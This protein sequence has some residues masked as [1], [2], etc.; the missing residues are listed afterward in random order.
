[1][2]KKGAII[3]CELGVKLAENDIIAMYDSEGVSAF[4]I[5]LPAIASGESYGAE[6]DGGIAFSYMTATKGESNEVAQIIAK[7]ELAFSVPGG[8]YDAKF[9][10]ELSV[11][12]GYTIY[13]TLDG[14]T[15]TAES[16]V[17][18]EPISITNRSGSNF[19]Y[20]KSEVTG[21]YAPSSLN[22]G[23]VVR[24]IAVDSKGAVAW[25]KTESYFVGLAN[26]SDYRNM[27]VISITTDPKNLFDYFEGIYVKGRTY[28]DAVAR[29][30][31]ATMA[32]NYHMGWEKEAYIE[33]YESNKD[34][35]YEGSVSLK[36]TNDYT[37]ANNQKSFLIKGEGAHIGSGLET[38]LNDI[39]K[40]L[41]LR[42]NNRDHGYKLRDYVAEELFDG[43]AA[44]TADLQPCI[45][46]I[47]GEYWGG[48]MLKEAYDEAYI[49][50]TY[51]TG[52]DKVVIVKNGFVNDYVYNS[53]YPEFRDFVINN[54]MS[55]TANYEMVK[56]QMDIQSY[57]DYICANMYVANAAYG[58]ESVIWRTAEVGGEGYCDGKWR[59]LFSEMTMTMAN[60]M[61]GNVST[62]S[63]DTFLQPGITQDAFLQSLLMN[64][65]FCSQLK[66][67][68]EKMAGETFAK[69]AVNTVLN[70]ISGSMQK[71]VLSSYKRFIGNVRDDYYSLEV[72][73]VRTFF[74]E[75]SEY[76]LFYTEELVEKGGDME[77]V[78]AMREML[79]AGEENGEE[80]EITGSSGEEISN[81]ELSE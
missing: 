73:K 74:E 28:E 3:V 40:S 42:T 20:A 71:F 49:K 63:I 46:F 72:E 62:A 14:T 12:E 45:V 56:K 75:R 32:A 29:G 79:K 2:M 8:F 80:G 54:D 36:I 27:P 53:L 30:E 64:K 34:K 68:M 50:E 38:Y 23:T 19:M 25:D 60:G 59:W 31:N 47:N 58:E 26:A 55:L 52:D 11:P 57:L 6:A 15:P 81:D 39:T 18:S 78:T 13:Y 70:E 67:T 61:S 69:E 41:M 22:M 16:A 76:I 65:E 66:A 7:N 33:Y 21:Y 37:I 4:H 77:V 5:M 9:E 35:T 17:Y 44:G 24:A 10:L 43:L 1:L 51:N 48:Y